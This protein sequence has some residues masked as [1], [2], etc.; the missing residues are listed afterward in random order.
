MIYAA[1]IGVSLSDIAKC[2]PLNRKK[3]R[4]TDCLLLDV[5]DTAAY[6][7]R[8]C[9]QPADGSGSTRRESQS[10]QGA[11]PPERPSRACSSRALP[12]GRVLR[13]SRPAASQIRDVA[14]GT[15]RGRCKIRSRH[16]VRTVATDILSGRGR[17]QQRRPERF[18]TSTTRPQ[19]R[20][21]T[22]RRS[23]ALHRES[24]A[25]RRADSCSSTGARDQGEARTCHSSAQHRTRPG[26]QKKTLTPAAAVPLSPAALQVYEALRTEV[27]AGHARPE[28][29]CAVVHHGLLR[30]ATLLLSYQASADAAPPCPAAPAPFI[31][32]RE[33]LHLVAN[34]VLQAHSE[35]SHVY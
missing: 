31:Q 28:G 32:H 35:V 3:A 21:Q 4:Y 24:G 16:D 19:G 13:R 34:M 12:V 9:N 33:F 1:E 14:S 18:T 23:D 22:H 8:H 30:G 15:G 5:V 17:V 20:S 26:A 25:N 29:L 6:F 7:I 27:I 2:I 11:G 10:P